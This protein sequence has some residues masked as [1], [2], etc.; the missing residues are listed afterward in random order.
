[1]PDHS[2]ADGAASTSP[3]RLQNMNLLKQ[4]LHLRRR[5]DTQLFLQKTSAEAV[6]THRLGRVA[7]GEMDAD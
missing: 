4:L 6:L 1:M 5:L 2:F 3:D 7:L